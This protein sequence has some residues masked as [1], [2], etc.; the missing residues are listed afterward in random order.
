[1]D[2]TKISRPTPA[3]RKHGQLRE[4]LRYVRR[5]PELFGPLMLMAV[6][7]TLAY[8][9]NIMLPLLAKDTFDGD[10]RLVG[11]MFTAM[12]VG[13][14]LGALAL[15]GTMVATT[16]RLIV[17][18]LTFAAVLI[19]SGLVPSV[20]IALFMLFLLGASSV[21][22]R[23]VAT[24]LLQLSSDPDMRGRVIS[25]FVVAVAG[26]TSI[27]GP[28]IG[29]IGEHFGARTAFLIG[30]VG[31]ALAAGLT[32]LYL[33]RR[34]VSHPVDADIDAGDATGRPRPALDGP[35]IDD[36]T[37]REPPEVSVPKR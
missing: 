5:R 4:G 30:G 3:P 19:A 27:G 17:G 37:L 32:Y 26:T 9:F 6:T 18:G 13:A 21:S 14:I 34:V 22:F 29:S 11:Y 23:S 35:T 12:G 36:L 24:S 1:M 31:T 25:L 20:P 33:R 28:F 16:P 10:A 15:A 7:G 2:T 8:N